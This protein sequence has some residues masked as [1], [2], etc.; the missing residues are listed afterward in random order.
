MAAHNIQFQE[1]TR[2]NQKNTTTS[3]KNLEIQMGQIAQ[4]L[5]SNSQV[6][7][8]LP[9]GTVVNPR[10]QSHIKAVVTRKGKSNKQQVDEQVEEDGLLEVDLEI[11][12]E[13]KQ[14]EEVV[15]KPAS[16]QEKQ[17][18]KIILPFSTRTKKQDL[19]EFFFEKF[20]ELFKKLEINIPFV[21]ALEQMV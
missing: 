21:E 5:A 7:G 19:H 16:Q 1:E 6:P 10:D 12:E 8:T 2:N 11:R 14:A 18:P 15:V 17:K 3:I 9:S 13:P 20:L 4:Q